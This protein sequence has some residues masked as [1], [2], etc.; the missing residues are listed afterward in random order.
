MSDVN[1]WLLA[2]ADEIQEPD[3]KN[4]EVEVWDY[5]LIN[6]FRGVAQVSL[7]DVLDNKRVRDTFRCAGSSALWHIAAAGMRM[8]S[9]SS[10]QVLLW[11]EISCQ[12][13]DLCRVQDGR[14]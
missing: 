12:D 14:C 4:I 3:R 11:Q 8:S 7:K 9:A 10:W 1:T 13:Q 5:K 6:H 2:G